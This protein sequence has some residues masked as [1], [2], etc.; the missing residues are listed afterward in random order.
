MAKDSN[1]SRFDD[2]LKRIYF[3]PSLRGSFSGVNS[4]YDA[5]K[6]IDP[7]IRIK[8]VRHFLDAQSTYVNYRDIRKRFA[9]R[10]YVSGF[11]DNIW[12]IDLIE[13]NQK[14]L[15][16]INRGYCYILVAVDFFSRYVD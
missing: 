12:G 5:A 6:L 1:G 11:T 4:L 10:M 14:N 2:V 16:K 7:K 13:M 3:N 8:D 9:R 15:K